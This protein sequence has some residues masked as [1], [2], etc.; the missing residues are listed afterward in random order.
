ME[1]IALRQAVRALPERERQIIALR[2]F[3]GLTQQRTAGILGISQV[4]VSRVER[5][6]LGAVGH[7]EVRI[8]ALVEAVD[9]VVA[10]VD[11]P[12]LEAEQRVAGRDARANQAVGPCHVESEAESFAA[13]PVFLPEVQLSRVARET[14]VHGGLS[15]MVEVAGG[16][17]HAEVIGQLSGLLRDAELHGVEYDAARGESFDA[18][19]ERD[20]LRIVVAAP[21]FQRVE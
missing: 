13:R 5:K 3:H 12:R 17:R 10:G 4:Q 2:Y 19:P 7:V 11:L 18:H 21:D 20:G 16:V 1:K 8:H 6:A 15:H 14:A 9:E